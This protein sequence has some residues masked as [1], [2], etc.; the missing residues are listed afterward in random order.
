MIRTYR[1][2]EHNSGFIGVRVAVMVNGKPMQKYFSFKTANIKE[3]E[4]L[5]KAK[6]LH[7]QWLMEKSLAS[8]KREIASK[9]LRRVLGSSLKSTTLL[10]KILS[11]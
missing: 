2:G 5:T 6:Q 9:E 1:K 3:S 7:T 4:V 8:S 11:K 10:I